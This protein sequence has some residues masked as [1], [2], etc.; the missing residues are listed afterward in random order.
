MVRF[1]DSMSFI[2]MLTGK[3]GDVEN[4]ILRGCKFRVSKDNLSFSTCF[5][6]VR[7][8]YEDSEVDFRDILYH[9]TGR[10]DMTSRARGMMT[11]YQEK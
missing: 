6:L 10:K 4:L 8:Y 7:N 1:A 11:M 9:D 3:G 5:I 2:D